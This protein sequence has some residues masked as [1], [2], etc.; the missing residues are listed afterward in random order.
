MSVLP[1]PDRFHFKQ[2]CYACPKNA[3]GWSHPTP[4]LACRS[5]LALKTRRQFTNL[6]RTSQS[7]HVVACTLNCGSNTYNGQ[8]L[9]WVLASC[10]LRLSTSLIRHSFLCALFGCS[11]LLFFAA[12]PLLPLADVEKSTL[13]CCCG[14]RLDVSMFHR[15]GSAFDLRLCYFQ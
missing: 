8:C 5:L 2:K 12:K 9:F 7:D 3:S 10:V 1:L 13:G 11:I 14:V 4:L 6:V 15:H